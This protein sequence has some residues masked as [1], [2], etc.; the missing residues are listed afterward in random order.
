M[1]SSAQSHMTNPTKIWNHLLIDT[2]DD[3]LMLSHIFMWH[4][5]CD[6]WSCSLLPSCNCWAKPAKIPW[7]QAGILQQVKHR[8]CRQ[9]M[10]HSQLYPS[11]RPKIQ[12]QQLNS[13]PHY[14]HKTWK[15][16]LQHFTA[17]CFSRPAH[18]PQRCVTRWIL[19][20]Q[21]SMLETWTGSWNSAVPP[22]KIINKRLNCRQSEHDKAPLSVWTCCCE[23]ELLSC[24]F[25]QYS[26]T[27]LSSPT[28]L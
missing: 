21:Y 6:L 5:I 26:I 3:R 16:Q 2:F 23:R 8:N 25:V 14:C 27:D 1:L 19:E 20:S 13:F 15:I 9:L 12:P 28:R 17:L 18:R 22:A 11:L 24:S 7:D 4:L 10:P